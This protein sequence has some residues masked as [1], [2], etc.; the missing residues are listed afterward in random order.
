MGKVEF[1][2]M[3][4]V[5]NRKEWRHNTVMQLI[6]TSKLDAEAAIK[7]AKKLEKYVFQDD[8]IVE[9]QN[10][11]QKVALENLIKSLEQD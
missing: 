2:N 5:Q 6:E 7:E 10:E 11:E 9:I 1:I 3:K 8:L 4:V